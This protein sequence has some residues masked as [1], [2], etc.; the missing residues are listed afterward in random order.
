M[1][2]CAGM[3]EGV[4]LQAEDDHSSLAVTAWKTCCLAKTSG[5]TLRQT[6]LCNTAVTPVSGAHNN[7]TDWYLNRSVP[8]ASSQQAICKASRHDTLGS[9]LCRAGI[10]RALFKGHVVACQA[11]H[12]LHQW[13]H[14]QQLPGP[15]QQHLPEHPISHRLTHPPD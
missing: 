9:W 8:H 6:L 2:I 10:I 15:Q 13:H 3:V 12:T 7:S 1:Y 4:V 11:V 14:Q 5:P